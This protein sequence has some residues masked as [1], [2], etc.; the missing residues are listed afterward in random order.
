MINDAETRRVPWPHLAAN[1]ILFAFL[2]G[3]S[4]AQVSISEF[5]AQSHKKKKRERPSPSELSDLGGVNL[6]QKK[7]E[8]RPDMVVSIA[9]FHHGFGD[10]FFAQERFRKDPPYPDPL[11]D[12]RLPTI[13]SATLSNGLRL[14]VLRKQGE[15]VMNLLL[16]ISA[17]ES[18]SPDNAPGIATFTANMLNRGAEGLPFSKII[19][20]IESMGGSFTAETFPDYS[21]FSFAF[22]ED[23]LE[24]ALEILGRMILHPTFQRVEM[25]NVIRTMYFDL[26]D[27]SKSPEVVGERV[28][29]NILFKDHPY[30]KIAFNETVRRN[31]DR[32]GLVDF[33]EKYYCP[34]NAEIV[35]IGNI[36]LRIA[37]RKV[38]RYLNTWETKDIEPN[39]L[40]LPEPNQ[41]VKICLV[42]LPD[43]KDAMVYMGN[44]VL[45]QNS[46][47][48]FPLTV[49]NQVIG[50]SP[51]SRLFMNLRESKG[52]AYYAFSS[53]ELF[54]T[55]AL[56][57]ITERVR[58]EVISESIRESLRELEKVSTTAIPNHELEQAKSYLIGRFPLEIEDSS[59]FLK[60]LSK[61]KA[62]NQG[63]D[64][65]MQYY[66]NLMLINAE[67]VYEIAA[68]ASL[69]TPVIVI[70]GPVQTLSEQLSDYDLDVYD[71]N[72]EHQ[73]TI[74]KGVLQ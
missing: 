44:T 57:T 47:D 7:T 41:K 23:H 12:L 1:F 65:W 72:G 55:C 70:M 32:R 40:P 36:T 50:G 11:S 18:V 8:A 53:I 4:L 71:S 61:L 20:S 52:F 46:K 9:N 3:T 14:S 34:N 69:N 51:H 49:L 31:L 68:N 45:L 43:E 24:E 22:L 33:F 59:N 29:Y 19:E 42:D 10:V 66:K 6:R 13:E 27:K 38:S 37:A 21:V 67:S 58:T 64:H 28:L 39:S 2:V 16:I 25:D 5:V 15:P 62:F 74:K 63:D 48:Y 54:R 30:R 60:K 17:G 73:Y 26:I 35:L 56:L